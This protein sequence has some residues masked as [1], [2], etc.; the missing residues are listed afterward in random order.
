MSVFEARGNWSVPGTGT[1]EG[2]PSSWL[3]TKANSRV[4][5][6]YSCYRIYGSILFLPQA[7]SEKYLTYTKNWHS[8]LRY[9][10]MIPIDSF[11]P[12]ALFKYISSRLCTYRKCTSK[13]QENEMLKLRTSNP[14]LT[15]NT[16]RLESLVWLPCQDNVYFDSS[17]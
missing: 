10:A 1:I 2:N 6:V 5:N 17:I 14:I 7:F 13:Q 3:E 16:E 4:P 15:S 9:N 12:K 11:A 8:C